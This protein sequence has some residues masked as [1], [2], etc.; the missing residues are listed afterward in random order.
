MA[1]R[2]KSHVGRNRN[3]RKFATMGTA[4]VNGTVPIVGQEA[5]QSREPV[6]SSYPFGDGAAS[7]P[8]QCI[9]ALLGCMISSTETKMEGRAD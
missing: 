3:C 6:W 5:A 1:G 8:D 9:E 2:G 7:L 4:N